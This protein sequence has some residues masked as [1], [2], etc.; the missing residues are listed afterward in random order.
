MRR[1]LLLACGAVFIDTAFLTVIA[2]LLPG[3]VHHLHLTTAQAGVLSAAYA[4]GTLAA[5]LPAGFVASRFGPR[6]TTII[7]LLGLGLASVL[8]GF[9]KSIYPLDLARFIQ[10]AAGALIWSG[11]LT[12]LIGTYPEEKRGAVIGT[13]LGTAV[14]G[15][16]LGPVLGALA[17]AV[18][19][20]VVFSAVLAAAL[21]AVAIA[22]RLPDMV[23]R[24]SQPL[25]EVL[26]CLIDR[27]LVEAAF[28]VGSPSL[29]YGAIDVLVPL[30]INVLGGGQGLIAAAFIGGAAIE[31]VLSP[32]AGRLADRVGRRAPYVVGMGIC[33]AAMLLFAAAG[34]LAIVV[35][36]LL[37]ISFGSGLCFA[38]AMAL[39]SDRAAESGLHQGY[40]VGVTNMAWAA[41]QVLGGVVGAGV[42]GV[43]GD[44]APS[45]GIAVLLAVTM[46]YAARSLAPTPVEAEA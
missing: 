43:A 7:G 10:G 35:A 8:F 17:G 36:S 25:R 12:W 45:I 44:A 30:R 34:S 41:A 37:V 38:P 1:L 3:Y 21:V 23:V 42:A 31:S 14:A 29:L 22:A 26:A 32:I 33:A 27:P 4:A 2:P 6:R 15:S 11:A 9:L 40:A 39:I 46:A 18:G 28:F 5:S 13:A 16:L 19:T 24:E 20:E